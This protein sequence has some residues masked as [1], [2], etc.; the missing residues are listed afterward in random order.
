MDSAANGYICMKMQEVAGA[1]WTCSARQRSILL[2][3]ARALRPNLV[4]NQRQPDSR[5]GN[6]LADGW[7]YGVHI[8]LRHLLMKLQKARGDMIVIAAPLHR[9]RFF[10]GHRN[11]QF[12]V[13][14]RVGH[15]VAFP[16]PV[17]HLDALFLPATCV[18]AELVVERRGPLLHSFHS[19][20]V[21]NNSGIP[22]AMKIGRVGFGLR[23]SLHRRVAKEIDGH[24]VAPQIVVGNAMQ[25]LVK[26]THK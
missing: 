12:G 1:T 3:V 6:L 4:Q 11:R 26:V 14:H 8:L 9:H 16:S 25:R 10:Y 7:G 15:L 19:F 13:N 22:D 5:L 18:R 24:A 17:I 20:H 21:L 23:V 2:R